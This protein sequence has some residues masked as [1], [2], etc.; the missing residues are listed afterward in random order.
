MM[1]H[2]AKTKFDFLPNHQGLEANKKAQ[3]RL[4]RRHDRF[5]VNS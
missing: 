3:A 2:R 1:T 4:A 5:E